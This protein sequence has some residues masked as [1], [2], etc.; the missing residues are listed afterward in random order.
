MAEPVEKPFARYESLDWLRGL[1]ALSIMLY[2]LIGWDIAPLK[3][4]TLLG[5]LG[6]YSVSMFF[7]L[8]GLSIALAYHRYFSDWSSVWR[9]GVRRAFRI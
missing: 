5:R 3:A 2:H 6:A 1:L 4:D 8:S 7:V 9:F